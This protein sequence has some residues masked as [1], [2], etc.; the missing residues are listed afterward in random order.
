MSTLWFY[1]SDLVVSWFWLMD[2]PLMSDKTV[3]QLTNTALDKPLVM[4]IFESKAFFSLY[5]S[6]QAPDISSRVLKTI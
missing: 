3:G 1:D 6:F 4:D 2:I 5:N